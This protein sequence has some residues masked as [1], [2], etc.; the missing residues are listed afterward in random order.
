MMMAKMHY[1]VSPR[2][3]EP[4]VGVVEPENFECIMNF[5]LKR[6]IWIFSVNLDFNKQQVI[7][8]H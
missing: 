4:L 1:P 7:A 2:K 6:N 3:I 8:K 5:I